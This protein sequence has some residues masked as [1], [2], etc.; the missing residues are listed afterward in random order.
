MVHGVGPPA[1]LVPLFIDI[2]AP[3]LLVLAI[4]AIVV[5]GPEKLPQFARKA[6]QALRYIRQMAGSAQSQLRSELGPEFDDLDITDLNPK[7]FVRKHLLSDIEPVVHDVRND[8]N[9]AARIGRDGVDDAT[10]AIEDVKAG[11]RRPVDL[12]GG[13]TATT[14]P[15][16]ATP[17]S[18][19]YDSDAT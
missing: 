8:L 4:V 7:S 12:G 9:D 14:V 5:F 17:A 3:E 10:A 18:A 1:L 11:A 13:I 15:T 2:G 19:P 6:A 16:A